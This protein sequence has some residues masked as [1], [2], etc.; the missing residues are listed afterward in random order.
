MQQTD[1]DGLDPLRFE[2]AQHRERAGTIE[3][4]RDAAVGQDA[5]GDLEPAPPRDQR[6]GRR[7]QQVERVD[8][9]A[10]RDLEHVAEARGCDEPAARAFA[11]DDRVDRDRAAVD[12]VVE[13]P[14]VELGFGD[15]RGNAVRDVGGRAGLR[16][17]QRVGGR[18]VSGQIGERP[19]D[20][21]G[22]TRAHARDPRPSGDITTP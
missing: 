14:Q 18:I 5:L 16:D 6:L 21:G 7:E 20:V 15:G 4:P 12:E 11:L 10:A 13:T 19:A 17:R 9:V 22:D 3:R 2:L 8:D 1:G